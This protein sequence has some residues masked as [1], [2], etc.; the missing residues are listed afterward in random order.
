VSD[1]DV[2]LLLDALRVLVGVEHVIVDADI[3]APFVTDWTGRFTG[4]TPAVVRPGSTEEVASVLTLCRD[5][6]VAWVPQ[7]GNTGLVGGGVPV[8]GE[9]V[10]STTRLT[11]LGAVDQDSGQV[12]VG[13]GVTLASLQN[14]AA[15]GGWRFGV[16]FG[17]RDRA[18]VGGMVA[19][20]AGGTAVLRFGMMSEQ[21][22]G[23]EAVLADGSV[24]SRLSGLAK[25]NT[26]YNLAA[27]LCGSE[28]T[29]GLITAVRV[30]LRPASAEVTTVA[31]SVATLAGAFQVLGALRT[32]E[33]VEACELMRSVD[34]AAL[35]AARV[36]RQPTPWEAPW[37]MLIEAR[38]AGRL[39][40]LLEALGD[41][42]EIVGEPV[43]ADRPSVRES[44]WEIRDGQGDVARQFGS[45]LKLDVSVPHAA[46]ASFVETVEGIVGDAGPDARLVLFGHLGDA[47]LHVNVAAPP[48]A[49]SALERGILGA[50]LAA[51]GSISAEHGIGRAKRDWLVADRGPHAVAAMRA[52]KRA[53]DPTGLA[54]PH[55][56]FEV[57]SDRGTV[58]GR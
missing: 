42:S 33:A 24:V 4:T 43:L 19:T 50:V 49:F 26:G 8:D 58:G 9:L 37:A 46:M 29:L 55:V 20:N 35:C 44:W 31:L 30:R 39:D 53:L 54:N 10:I 14:L 34:I 23:V 12:T 51:G 11:T 56:L 57:D 45:A 47:N 16:D 22:V 32:V 15:A 27:L 28:G 52:I 41:L 18:T 6:G 21:I 13:A 3:Q 7:G 1:P 48:A 25:D 38:G 36:W 5:F 2:A 17:A 40:A